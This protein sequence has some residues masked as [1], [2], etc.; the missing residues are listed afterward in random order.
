[1][2]A[3]KLIFAA[4]IALIVLIAPVHAFMECYPDRDCKEDRPYFRIPIPE[5][6]EG[7]NKMFTLFPNV[8]CE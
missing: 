5:R 7:F 2:L 4:L 3:A 1:M 8:G 6:H